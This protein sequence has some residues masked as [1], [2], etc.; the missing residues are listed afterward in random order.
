MKKTSKWI[1]LVLLMAF[2]IITVSSLSKRTIFKNKEM[3]YIAKV[4]GKSFYVYSDKG[5]QEKFLKGVNMG[6]GKPGY[7]PGELAISKDEY[8][9]WFKYISDM[10]ADVIRVYTTLK[11]EFYNALYEFNKSSKKPLYIMQGVWVKEETMSELKDAYALD[12]K[13]KKEFIRDSQDLVDIFHGDAELPVKRGFA[14][15][16]YTKDISQYVIGWILGIEWD[17]EFVDT[18]DKNNKDKKSSYNGKY[19]YT[20]Y[21]PAFETFLAEVGDKIVDYEKEEYGTTRPVSYTNWL[22]TDPLKH[23]NEPMKKEDMVSID[24]ELIKARKDFKPGVFASYH[25]YPYY[26]DFMNY[27]KSILRLRTKKVK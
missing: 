5:W 8:M 25:V 19:L 13:I 4:E 2:A 20:Q 9:R 7:F 6:L 3:E 27:Q 17:P 21:A 1:F 23:P 18:T 24:V 15:G 14:S 12:G 10:N 16:K 11:P 26:P 22:T